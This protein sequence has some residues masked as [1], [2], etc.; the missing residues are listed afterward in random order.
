MARNLQGFSRLVIVGAWTCLAPVAA[1]AAGG[2]HVAPTDQAP[3]GQHGPMQAGYGRATIY[4]ADEPPKPVHRPANQAAAKLPAESTRTPQPAKV[5]P[6]EEALPVIIQ[7][8]PHRFRLH[9]SQRA[10]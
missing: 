4:R 8:V 7:G 6:T 2:R 10:C 5:L 3:A 1:L 9:Y